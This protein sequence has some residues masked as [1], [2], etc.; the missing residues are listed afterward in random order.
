MLSIT[1]HCIVCY[2]ERRKEAQKVAGVSCYRDENGL[3][4]ALNF[5]QKNLLGQKGVETTAAQLKKM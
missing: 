4:H 5:D 2:R 3:M 1:V